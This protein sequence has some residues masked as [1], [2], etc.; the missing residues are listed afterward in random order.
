MRQKLLKAHLASVRR[1]FTRLLLI[2]RPAIVHYRHPRHRQTAHARSP[3]RRIRLLLA[4]LII[5]L[6]GLRESR[7]P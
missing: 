7:V 2:V 3:R 5:R 1:W 6:M 4:G